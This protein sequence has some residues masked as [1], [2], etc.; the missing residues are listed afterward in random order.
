ME[1]QALPKKVSVPFMYLVKEKSGQVIKEQGF[2]NCGPALKFLGT[3]WANMSDE[4]KQP[5][6]D[7]S[8]QDAKR[9]A[10]QYDELAQKGYFTLED[11]TKSSDLPPKIRKVKKDSRLVPHKLGKRAAPKK[12]TKAGR[13]KKVVK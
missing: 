13:T 1:E 6:V 7:L 12:K 10:N 3:V 2:K 8:E 4:E 11:G 9:Q 5:Y